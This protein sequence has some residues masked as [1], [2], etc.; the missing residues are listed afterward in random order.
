MCINNLKEN[1]LV[2]QVAEDL[3]VKVIGDSEDGDS[4]WWRKYPGG[5]RQF[6]NSSN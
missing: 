4:E 5:R 2:K 3:H 6:Y 1:E